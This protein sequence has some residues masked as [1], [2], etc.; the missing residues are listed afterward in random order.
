MDTNHNSYVVHGHYELS[1]RRFK[2]ARDVNMSL[3]LISFG[4]GDLYDPNLDPILVVFRNGD[5]EYLW[6]KAIYREVGIVFREKAMLAD[7]RRLDDDALTNLYQ[8]ISKYNNSSVPTPVGK[9][10]I[11]EPSTYCRVLYRYKN[12]I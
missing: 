10:S 2:V 3:Y 11:I 5:R 1:P 4:L 8:L 7:L 12:V 9:N 6:R